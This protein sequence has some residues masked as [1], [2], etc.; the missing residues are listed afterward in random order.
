MKFH[1]GHSC[2]QTHQAAATPR[3][4]ALESAPHNR[5]ICFLA[6]WQWDP[7]AALSVDPKLEDSENT[8][9]RA[10]PTCIAGQSL[11]LYLSFFP[12]FPSLY[13]QILH[14]WPRKKKHLTKGKTL[15][16]GNHEG[17]HPTTMRGQAWQA[18]HLWL[19]CWFGTLPEDLWS[20]NCGEKSFIRQVGS[21][22]AS[23]EVHT[24]CSV[25]YNPRHF[26]THMFCP[27]PPNHQE[28]ACWNCQILENSHRRWEYEYPWWMEPHQSS[29]SNRC[30]FLYSLFRHKPGFKEA[31][32]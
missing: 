16:L 8:K 10:A 18:K 22:C 28:F 14:L 31:Q 17:L 32:H 9:G 20:P 26:R 21:K 3:A 13:N 1:C 24:F 12:K 2:P 27:S 30:L 11:T 29:W 5:R 19:Q 7:Q 4:C 23:P 6:T 25:V 15:A